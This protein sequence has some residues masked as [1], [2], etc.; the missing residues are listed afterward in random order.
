[1]VLDVSYY[2][3]AKELELSCTH[4][5]EVLKGRRKGAPALRR[6]WDFLDNVESSQEAAPVHEVV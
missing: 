1:M 6:I 2:R 4:V 5:Q 3:L